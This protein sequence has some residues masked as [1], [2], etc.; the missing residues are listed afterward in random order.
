MAILAAAGHPFAADQDVLDIGTGSGHIAAALS[1]H[2]RVVASDVIDQRTVARDLPFV[3]ADVALPF[4][5]ASFDV[6]I[7][8]HVIEHCAAPA[9]HLKEIHRV[10]RPGGVLYLATPNRW[11]PWEVHTQ[12]PLLHYLPTALFVALAQLLGRLHEPL[13]LLSLAALRRMSRTDYSLECWHPHIVRDPTQ[14]RVELPPWAQPLTRCL[15]P[16]LLLATQ[17]CQPTLIALL[18]PQ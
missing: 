6:V 18:Y 4:P 9:R 14:F 13:H 17:G 2:A 3:A 8:N 10:L 5:A 7:S 16:R 15:P 12:L 11:W 1:C